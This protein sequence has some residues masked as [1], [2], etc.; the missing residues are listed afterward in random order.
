MSVNKVH[1][2]VDQKIVTGWY[3]SSLCENSSRAHFRGSLY[4]SR[5]GDRRIQTDLWGRLQLDTPSLR[6]FT[7]ARSEG[8]S[9]QASQR[10]RNRP[11]NRAARHRTVAAGGSRPT[12]AVQR[13]R[14]E[15]SFD[16]AFNPYP[17]F[18]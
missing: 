10:S 15:P 3:G 2:S 7:Q 9:R 6:V 1:R 13:S 4:P 5:G 8:G 18:M 12:A 11:P 17:S 14:R 16:G